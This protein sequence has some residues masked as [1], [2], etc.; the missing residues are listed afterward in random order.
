MNSPSLC[1]LKRHK[2]T[3]G[4]YISVKVPRSR[5]RVVVLVQGCSRCS[6]VKET[7]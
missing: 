1:P 2:Y 6:A 7:R 5:K 4:Y 3:L